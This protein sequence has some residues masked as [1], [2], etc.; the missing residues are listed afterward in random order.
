[1]D[2]SC[3]RNRLNGDLA[4][5]PYVVGRFSG[6]ADNILANNLYYWLKKKKYEQNT[7]NS[8]FFEYKLITTYLILVFYVEIFGKIIFPQI[9]KCT[10]SLHLGGERCQQFKKYNPQ[11]INIY[12]III[13]LPFN[14]RKHKN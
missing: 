10:M 4:F 12:L 6:D 7:I 1:M 13:W 2:A 5:I 11:R 8:S 14:L 3:A 9:G